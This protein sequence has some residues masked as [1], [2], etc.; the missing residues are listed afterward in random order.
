[1]NLSVDLSGFKLD[2][3]IIPASGTFGYGYEFQ[4]FYDINILGT[5]STKGTTKE[6]RVGNPQSRIAETKSGMINSIG[7]QNPGID[8]VLN[9]EL[10]KLKEVYTKDIILNI[11]GH[12]IEEYI[13]CIK[14][15]SNEPIVKI[16]ELNI[17]CPNV[18]N[19]GVGFGKDENLLRELL[20]E[21]RLATEKLVYVKLN[22]NV[23]DIVKM[24]KICEEEK[25]DGVVLINTLLGMRLD[26]NKKKPI[27][28]NTFGGLSGA[29]IFPVALHCVYQVYKEINIP[30]IGVGGITCTDDVIEMMMAGA[31]AVQIGSQNLIDPYICETIIKE[32]PER[33]QQLGYKNIED[34]IGV[35][36][37]KRCNNCT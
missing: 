2:N 8:D 13:D 29:C 35:A 15:A 16:I 12:S 26:I 4:K 3:P 22:P 28:H 17:S 5:F 24:A 10:K 20:K 36:N 27:I 11:G 6:R 31:S 21:V 1:M 9:K 18:S 33:L 32:L 23:T 25:M 14:K 37:E 30:I 19:G 7:L 34:I